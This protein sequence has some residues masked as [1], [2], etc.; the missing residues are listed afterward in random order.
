MP[1]LHTVLL[2]C[3]V[4]Q[5]NM[6]KPPEIELNM[7]GAAAAVNRRF[8]MVATLLHS[9]QRKYRGGSADLRVWTSLSVP[10]ESG[11]IAQSSQ[12]GVKRAARNLNI[13]PDSNACTFKMAFYICNAVPNTHA[14][15]IALM[16]VHRF[17]EIFLYSLD[18]H[19]SHV[20]LAKL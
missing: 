19:N 7:H 13:F 15:C 1:Y 16:K 2:R 6:F 18:S 8:S 3:S 5:L 4:R 20:A 9:K 12:S 17:K 11:Y 10:C 14:K